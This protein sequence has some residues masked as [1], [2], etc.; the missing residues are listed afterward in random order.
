M[1]VGG[2]SRLR[3]LRHGAGAVVSGAVAPVGRPVRI[4]QVIP[5]IVERDAVSHHTLEA[6]RVLRGL[7][8]VSEIYA[9]TMGPEMAGRVHPLSELPRE[10]G[11]RQWVCYQASIGSPAA[12]A[13]AEHPGPKLLDYHNITP[14]E[15]VEQWMP[16]LGDE[17][18]LGRVQLAELAPAV[19][20]GVGDSRYNTRELESWGY[21]RTRVSMLM[22]DRTNFDVAPDPVATARLSALARAEPGADWLF[23]GQMIPHKAHH[24][25]VA[26]FAA[27]REAYEPSARLHLVGRDSCPAYALGV[28]RYVE[29]LGLDDAVEIAGSVS[30][31]EL[32]A[33]YD[34]CDVYVCCS[35]HEGFCAPLLEAMHHGLPVVAYAAAAVP[36]TVGDA[37]VVLDTKAPAAV[38]AAVRRVLTDDGLRHRLVAAGRQRAD[39]FS[40][41]RARADFAAAIGE[42]LA[43]AEGAR[44]HPTA[45][46][47]A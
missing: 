39:S 12:E 13:V 43:I 35:D 15:L 41:E 20:L 8:F 7:G 10:Q 30:A 22:V 3:R 47:S 14:A 9:L 38:A 32:A 2:R 16:S 46:A 28:R 42:A 37:G 40:L 33:L 23:V 36:E 45:E 18:R 4:D 31:G 5:S 29:V 17:V 44:P 27:Y 26:A 6:Q 34:S 19:L 21:E 11:G 25:V 1:H 24:D